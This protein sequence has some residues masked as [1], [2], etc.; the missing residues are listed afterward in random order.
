MRTVV[1]VAW[2]SRTEWSELRK[3]APDADQLE[4]TYEEWLIV[5]E[6][7]LTDL[8]T[9]GLYPE[10]VPIAIGA[11]SAWCAARHRR[12][13]GAARAE[14]AAAELQR[15]HESRSTRSDA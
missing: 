11:L 1:G 6:R 4:V 8:R 7:G 9:A 10:R 5:F 14:Y 2:Y 12:P 3:I 15:L 13:D